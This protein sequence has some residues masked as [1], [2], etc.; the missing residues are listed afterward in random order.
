MEI[1]RSFLWQAAFFVEL[2][3]ILPLIL[4]KIIFN[5]YIWFFSY[6]IVFLKSITSGVPGWLSRLS[7]QLLISAQV[8]ISGFWVQALCWAPHWAW[9]LLKKIKNRGFWVAQTGKHPT[10]DCSSGHD[11]TVCGIEPHVGLC[12][13]STELAWDSPSLSLSK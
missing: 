3:C 7:V 8:L 2:F 5:N 11:L 13:G 12:T 4:L 10:L 1:Q 9:S 6:L